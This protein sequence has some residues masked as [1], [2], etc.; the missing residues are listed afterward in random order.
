MSVRDFDFDLARAITEQLVEHFDKMPPSPLGAKHL[1]DA[2]SESGV[3][4]L[5]FHGDLVY[6]GK[7]DRNLANRLERHCNALTGRLNIA[8]AEVTFKGIHIHPNWSALTTE[9]ALINHFGT[10][11]W[12]NS[13]FGSNDPGRNRDNTAVPP[14][15]FEGMF[16]I[17]SAHPI[18][19][20]SGHQTT[21][22][23]LRRTKSSLPY[24][25]RYGGSPV[26]K[27]ELQSASVTVPTGSILA[28]DALKLAARSLPNGWQA[29]VLPGRML[30]YKETRQYSSGRI[31]WPEQVSPA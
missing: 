7:S 30:L 29:T 6:V 24:L 16:P 21:E 11:N 20:Q 31:I 22:E 26:E 12:N 15:S 19:I 23:L 4:Q 17:D 13:G 5:F 28:E 10:T 14:E 27:K 1:S 8:L 9:A 3:Y 25:L 2:R 18:E